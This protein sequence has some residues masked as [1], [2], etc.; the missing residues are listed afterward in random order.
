MSEIRQDALGQRKLVKLEPAWRIRNTTYMDAYLKHPPTGFVFAYDS[1]VQNT[2]WNNLNRTHVSFSFQRILA[3]LL[4]IQLIKSGFESF[5]ARRPWQLLTLAMDHL[6]LRNEPWVLEMTFDLPFVLAG[7]DRTMPSFR[8]RVLRAL[9]SDNCRKIVCQ[10]RAGRQALLQQVGSELK[11]KTMIVP[12][13]IPAMQGTAG[14][15]VNR[16][17]RVDQVMLFVNSG[18]VDTPSSFYEKGGHYVVESFLR[19]QRDFPDLR[20]ILRSYVPKAYRTKIDG[21]RGICV[22]DHYISREK[23]HAVWNSATIFVHPHFGN[24]SNVLLEAMSYGLP[25]V[26][27]D[28]WATDEIVQDGVE[29]FLVS[30][31]L[32]HEYSEGAVFHC[33][34]RR[35][36]KELRNIESPMVDELIERLSLLIRNPDLAARIGTNGHQRILFGENSIARRN[37]ILGNVLE[38]V[39]AKGGAH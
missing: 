17:G 5:L 39:L 25:V 11:D 7:S 2:I 37:L 30:N 26:T 18:N 34:N 23:M 35:Y 32:S 13:A 29:G 21:V 9:Q 27:T 10:L 3:E 31:S 6:I 8:T 1:A 14:E 38:D 24:L 12:R 36:L 20:L 19:L 33:T 28:T 22:I 15:S 16:N 4:P